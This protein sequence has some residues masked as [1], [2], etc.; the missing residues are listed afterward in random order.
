[1]SVQGF[2]GPSAARLLAAGQ[3]P[4]VLDFVEPILDRCHVASVAGK[5]RGLLAAKDTPAGALLL[6]EPALASGESYAE[7]A[8]KLRELII[9]QP[10]GNSSSPATDD[11]L[12]GQILSLYA[13]GQEPNSV[14]EVTSV[15]CLVPRGAPATNAEAR[16]EVCR[17]LDLDSEDADLASNDLCAKLLARLELIARGNAFRA[18][19]DPLGALAWHSLAPREQ[20]S[21]A[22]QDPN[23]VPAPRLWFFQHAS[24]INH[25]ETPNASRLVAGGFIAVRAAQDLRAGDEV[26]ISYWPDVD[27]ADAEEHGLL[28]GFSMTVATIGVVPELGLSA[29]Q[30]VLFQRLKRSPLLAA[31]KLAEGAALGD[32]H[33]AFDAALSALT[34]E[35]KDA[36]NVLSHELRAFFEPR[37]LQAQIMLQQAAVKAAHGDTGRGDVLRRLGLEK[38]RRAVK[39]FPQPWGQRVLLRILFALKGVLR[40]APVALLPGIGQGQGSGDFAIQLA[41]QARVGSAELS[42]EL[43]CA[44]AAVFGDMALAHPVLSKCG[45]LLS[46]SE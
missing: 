40:P 3:R 39:Q 10:I 17:L 44:V 38:L 32:P 36:E 14:R 7:L 30:L 20:R 12:L 19:P 35:I 4:E 2:G 11:V 24:L 42:S 13:W 1:M 15:Q 18:A 31:E 8:A 27:A 26:L 16:A 43:E 34:T 41:Q 33:A 22:E 37:A 46:E 6:L 21:L 9:R 23:K 28:S 5:G 25:S 29:E 45:I